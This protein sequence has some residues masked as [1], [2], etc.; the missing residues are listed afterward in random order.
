MQKDY[1]YK[2][3]IVFFEKPK[4]IDS[5]EEM[6]DFTVHVK[7]FFKNPLLSRKQF[8]SNAPNFDL[9]RKF[10]KI[11]VLTTFRLLKSFTLILLMLPKLT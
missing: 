4:L 2:E 7:K 3:P 1:Y 11:H 10:I 5:D 9:K 6:S 8:V